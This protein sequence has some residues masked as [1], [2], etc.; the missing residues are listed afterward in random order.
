[1]AG[2]P[3]LVIGASPRRRNV[4]H[5]IEGISAFPDGADGIAAMAVVPLSPHNIP[6]VVVVVDDSA[7][8]RSLVP[9]R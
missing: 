3:R 4:V 6:M 5:M 8:A 9:R 2:H 7:D 1:M